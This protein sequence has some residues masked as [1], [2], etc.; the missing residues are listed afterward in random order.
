MIYL[1]Y[2]FIIYCNIVAERNE[3]S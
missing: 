3:L 1:K 2:T